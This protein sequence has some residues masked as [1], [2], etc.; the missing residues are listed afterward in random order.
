MRGLHIIFIFLLMASALWL[1][2]R[3][4]ISDVARNGA[5]V[6]T[7]APNQATPYLLQV[8]RDDRPFYKMLLQKNSYRMGAA[9]DCDVVLKG[10]DMPQYVGEILLRQGQCVLNNRSTIPVTIG[11]EQLGEGERVLADGCEVVLGNYRLSI[12]KNT[13]EG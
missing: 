12:D 8:F 10:S 2:I 1:L 5:V 3:S 11:H 13:D 6:P 4:L 7:P 9:K